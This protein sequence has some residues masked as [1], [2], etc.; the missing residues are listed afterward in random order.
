MDI[1]PGFTYRSEFI[2]KDE[3]SILISNIQNET[4]N[5]ELSRRTLHYGWKYPYS[6]FGKLERT[7]PIPKW[8]SKLKNRIE[9][10][11][12]TSFDQLI[13]NEY[14]PGQGIAP[15]IDHVGY[16]DETI[17]V[18]SLGSD[19]ELN[20]THS[21]RPNVKVYIQRRSMYAMQDIARYVYKHSITKRTHDTL[22]PRSTRYSLTFRKTLS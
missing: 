11:F 2:T 13:I 15:H 19:I 6:S 3:E 7:T 1:I 8:I 18:I 14:K 12:D 9:E 21:K 4:W 16:F 10:T 22:I 17:A 5:T 20:M